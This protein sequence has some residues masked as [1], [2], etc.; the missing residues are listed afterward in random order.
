MMNSNLALVALGGNLPSSAGC[1]T[2]TLRQSLQYFADIPGV[3]VTAVSRFWQTP[4]YPAGS[5]PDY[6]NACMSAECTLLPDDLLLAMHHIEARLG[7]VRAGARWQARGI[8]LDLIAFGGRV[9]PDA[10]TQDAWRALP[11]DQQALSA[12]D[13]LIVPHPRLQDRGFVLVPLAEIAP[14][15]RHPR[16][17]L[18]VAAMRAALPPAALSGIRPVET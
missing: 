8:D 10:A 14:G 3:A 9:L 4:A 16:L 5:G 2:E 12:P 18:T 15:W 6:V 17:G 7:R 11:P 13:E 1:V